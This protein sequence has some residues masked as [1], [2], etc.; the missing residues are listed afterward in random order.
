AWNGPDDPHDPYNW[1]TFRKVTIGVIFSLGQLVTTMSASMIAASLDDIILDLGISEAT[2]QVVFSTFFLGLAFGPFVIAAVAEMHGR[3]WIWVGAQSWY[4]L[5]NAL[6]PVGNSTG[7]MIV[8]RFMSGVGAASGTTLTGPVMADLYRK[9]ERGKSIAIASLLPYLGPALGPILGGFVT[10]WVQWQWTFWIMSLVNLVLTLAGLVMLRESYTPV[11]LRRKAGA[12]VAALPKTEQPWNWHLGMGFVARFGV[13]ILRPVMMLVRRPIIQIVSV[14]VAVD[15]GIYTL[16]LSTFATLWIRKYGETASQASLHYISI[17]IGITIA[18]QIGGHIMD[19]M[20]KRLRDQEM[21][22][23]GRPEFR[24]PYMLPGVIL[25]V[26]GLFWY[27]WAAERVDH[28]VVVDVGSVVFNLGNFVLNQALMAYQ[29]DEFADHAASA[30][31]ASKML[32]YLFGFM[33]P[34]FAPKLFDA[35]GYGWGNSLLG[36]VWLGLGG[37]VPVV[38]WVWGAKLR[39]TGRKDG[40]HGIGSG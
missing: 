11:L 40:E 4:I 22:G 16:Q 35:L 29:L 8:G 1:S 31:A 21:N 37:P 30:N 13:A 34:V 7:V 20:Y 33:F 15:F 27:G 28:W 5:W 10:Q 17:T 9:E 3:K 38:L 24:M 6:C 18:T 23:G 39:A 32:S 2:A 25:A 14:V 12:V 19:W 36:F 26:V